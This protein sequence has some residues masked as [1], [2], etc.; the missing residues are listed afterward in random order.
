MKSNPFECATVRVGE[1]MNRDWTSST[2]VLFLFILKIPFYF[3]I[4]IYVT[5]LTL[6]N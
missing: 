5:H 1:W 3:S 4:L 2:F 6:Y